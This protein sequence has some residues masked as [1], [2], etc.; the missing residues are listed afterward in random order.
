MVEVYDGELA[1]PSK[2]CYRNPKLRKIQCEIMPGAYNVSIT[3]RE[4]FA[5]A[6]NVV[7]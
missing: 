3:D 4:G 1:Y 6:V 7:G 2:Q 5:W